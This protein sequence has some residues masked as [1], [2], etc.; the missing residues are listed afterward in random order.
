MIQFYKMHGAGNDFVL[1]DNRGN[2][3]KLPDPERIRRI[4]QAHTGVGADGLMLLSDSSDNDF[5]LQYFNADGSKG[6]MCGN[7]ARCAVRFAHSLKMADSSCSFDIDNVQY[8]AEVVSDT[9]VKLA[10]QPPQMLMDAAQ[11]RVAG[12]DH[13]GPMLWLDT[14]VPHLVLLVEDVAEIDVV[15]RGRRLRHH[16]AFKPSGTN[17]N[18]LAA[19]DGKMKIRVYERGV[20]NETLACGTG[21]VA[22]AV[23]AARQFGKAAAFQFEVPGGELSVEFS[24]SPEKIY[25]CGPVTTVYKGELFAGF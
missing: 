12:V 13:P 19:A 25:L 20:E 17:V 21:A 14:G 23:F 1:I 6:E 11:L 16:A 8:Q 7:G 5:K 22:C 4:C 2:H 3:F 15:G 10:M 24:G 18:F 9:F